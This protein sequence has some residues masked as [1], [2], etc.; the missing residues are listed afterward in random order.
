METF[1]TDRMSFTISIAQ[2]QLL[3]SQD[4][5]V[6]RIPNNIFVHFYFSCMNEV[7]LHVRF[8]L[9]KTRDLCISQRKFKRSFNQTELSTHR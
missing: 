9:K 6:I 8:S 4:L 5:F 1:V 2:L 3:C 7:N